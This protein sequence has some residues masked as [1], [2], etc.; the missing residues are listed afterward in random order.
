MKGKTPFH[1]QQVHYEYNNPNPTVE[2]VE[3][4]EVAETKKV[5]GKAKAKKDTPVRTKEV[6]KRLKTSEYNKKF[7]L[8]KSYP[9]LKEMLEAGVPLKEVPTCLYESADALDNGITQSI[10]LSKVEE[11][12]DN[13]A[14]KPK[15]PEGGEEK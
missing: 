12:I 9:T 14:F 6:V 3:E 15:V 11:K 8:M 13:E 4:V 10:L 1:S 7:P 2:Y 5:R